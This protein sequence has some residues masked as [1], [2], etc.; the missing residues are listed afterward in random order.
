VTE[1]GAPRI[2]L[3]RARHQVLDRVRVEAL[4]RARPL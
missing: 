3:E 1:D 4:H 2:A